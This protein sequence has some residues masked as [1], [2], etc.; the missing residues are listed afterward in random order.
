MRYD[1]IQKSLFVE[2]RRRL[3]A[4]LQPKALAVVNNN[5]TLPTNADGSFRLHP[6]SD[7]FY[8]T[9]LEQE[10]S[11]LLLFPDA[12]EPRQ[13]EI[14]FVREPNALLETW[15]G[16][17]LSKE[18]AQKISG[19]ERVEWL[20]SFAG[21][22]HA[23]MGECERVYL[24]A[25][26]H[27]RADVP[28]Q[29]REA[30]FVRE[31][32]NRYPLH[33]YRRLAPLLYELRAVKSAAELA[34]LHRAIAIT[35]DGFQR[36]AR[37]V[38]PGV[39]ETQVEAEFAHEFIRQ[40]GGFAYT[41]IIGSGLNACALHYI[42][43]S[44]PCRSGELLLLDVASNYA[45]YNADLTRTIPVNG[46]FSRRQRQ[47]YNAVLRVFRSAA[48]MLRPGLRPSEWRQGVEEAMEKE[49]VDLQLL[50]MSEVRKQG[51]DKAALKRYY[52]HGIGHPIGLDVH[53]VAVP[54]APMQ[55]GWVVT[56]EPGIYIREEKMGVRLENMI[57]LTNSGSVDLMANIP[58]EPDDIEALMA[59]T[60]RAAPRRP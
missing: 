11:V 2:N 13:R 58:I 3:A 55:A 8:L 32:L 34:L 10:E 23:L 15:E 1:P 39:T 42:E 24:N 16:R 35:R 60:K 20:S 51:P 54:H 31:T 47:V 41:P 21:I 49:L 45:N 17:K 25:N 7:L 59:Q 26:E 56:C 44:A 50:K 5:D 52:M 36:V 29:T 57:Q 46:R 22:F 53:D 40:G 12:H 28:I 37:F 43:N 18:D 6:N 4:L 9:G 30:R 38:Q 19:I 27:A 48:A 33:D 14:L